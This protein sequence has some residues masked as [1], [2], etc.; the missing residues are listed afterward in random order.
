MNS[1]H[2]NC[3]RDKIGKWYNIVF[4]KLSTKNFIIRKSRGKN[5]ILDI[6][7]RNHINIDYTFNNFRDM[8]NTRVMAENK[9]HTIYLNSA[10][11]CSEGVCS[12]YPITSIYLTFRYNR[13]QWN[14]VCEND[15]LAV[16]LCGNPIK[17][18]AATQLDGAIRESKLLHQNAC[19]LAIHLALTFIDGFNKDTHANTLLVNPKCMTISHFEPQ[20][21]LNTFKI[22]NVLNL[23]NSLTNSLRAICK[24]IGYNYIGYLTPNCNFQDDN[25]EFCYLWTTWVELLAVLNPWVIPLNIGKYL[26]LR[27]QKLKSRTSRGA[28][29]ITFAKYLREIIE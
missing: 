22:N 3:R 7:A 6:R 16:G 8:A 27:Y 10:R 19:C 4:N 12:K 24:G 20:G 14:L 28:Q 13:G 26:R 1:C 29:A 9:L 2:K 23:T 11:A 21:S 5:G 25:P 17:H 18:Y 15:E